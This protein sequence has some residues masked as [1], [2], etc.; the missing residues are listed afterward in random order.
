VRLFFGSAANQTR[1]AEAETIKRKTGGKQI[2]TRARQSE[3]RNG[4]VWQKLGKLRK[5]NTATIIAI[6]G[7]FT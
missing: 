4:R 2:K 7:E 1:A 5:V 6:S 3:N